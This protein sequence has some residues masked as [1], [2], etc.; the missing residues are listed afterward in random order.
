MYQFTER[1]VKLIVAIIVE[2]RRNQL[3]TKCYPYTSISKSMGIIG[4]GSEVTYQLLNRFIA[5]I[6]YWRKGG[7]TNRQ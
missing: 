2:Y 5:F 4:T 6:N 3:P 7:S 1:W